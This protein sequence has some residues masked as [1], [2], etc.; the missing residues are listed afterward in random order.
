MWQSHDGRPSSHKSISPASS[1]RRHFPARG[2]VSPSDPNFSAN[3]PRVFGD[4]SHLLPLPGV[5]VWP[6]EQAWEDS[7]S[8]WIATDGENA[9]CSAVSHSSLGQ[10]PD[11]SRSNQL[12]AKSWSVDAARY[13]CNEASHLCNE[14]SHMLRQRHL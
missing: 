9:T 3:N 11:C 14:A 10:A 12:S 8:S 7:T 6:V 2:S 4:T 1:R 13:M 5:A